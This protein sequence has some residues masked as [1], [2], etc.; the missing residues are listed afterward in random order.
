M[1]DISRLTQPGYDG[2]T[3]DTLFLKLFGNE[4][5]AAFEE[6]SVM[7]ERHMVKQVQQGKSVTF[8]AV[9]TASSA[10][11][12]EG[13]DLLGGTYLSQIPHNERVITM[14][15]ILTSS[16]FVPEIQELKNHWS[17]RQEY[18]RQLGFALAKKFDQQVIKTVGLCAR[19]AA[20]V[21]G[22]LGGLSA[23]TDKQ[24]TNAAIHSGGAELIAGLF[25]AAE[26]LDTMNVPA[27]ADGRRWA[28]V[29]PAMYYNLLQVAP[30]AAGNPV[31]SRIGGSS[32]IAQGGN[33]PITI[34]GI[35]V[36]MSNHIDTASATTIETGTNTN[37]EAN[38][39]SDV[40]GYVFHEQAVGTAMLRDLTV[41]QD[42]VPTHLGTLMVGKMCVG[43]HYLRANCAVEINA[44]AFS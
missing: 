18:S 16:C 20:T 27:A 5:I 14:D 24:V 6:A 44:A 43:H 19:A 30:S 21:T 37:Y 38:D 10:Y 9:G 25:E 8:P 40:K 33:A 2:S 34:A 42:Y 35:K 4:V 28:I 13:A 22:E 1:A 39:N 7:R 29:T 36:I 15:A 3:Q 41:S 23:N 12:V 17:E 26:K 31:D 11:H 32:S